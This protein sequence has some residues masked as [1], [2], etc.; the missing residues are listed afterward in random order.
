MLYYVV[1]YRFGVLKLS[2]VLNVEQ[3][4]DRLHDINTKKLV[5][6]VLLHTL[7]SQLLKVFLSHIYSRK[8][9]CLF[10]VNLL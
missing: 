7:I 5:L 2:Y 9:Y 8:W 3:K 6:A 10:S 4:I 1:F